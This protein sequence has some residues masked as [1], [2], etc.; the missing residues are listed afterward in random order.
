MR[1]ILSLM[2]CFLGILPGQIKP[3]DGLRENPPRVWTLINSSVHTEPGQ[4]LEDAIIIIRDGII[5]NTGI[6][7][8]IPADATILDM[9]GKTIYPG[10]IDSWVEIPIESENI[11]YHDAHWN[12]K[13]N[14]RSEVYQ[15][16]KFLQLVYMRRL[17]QCTLFTPASF[18]VLQTP[19]TL[20]RI[21][22]RPV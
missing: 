1:I 15:L 9:S 14:A 18:K 11:P 3:T 20:W 4:I 21:S 22:Q 8:N 6:N 16:Y 2:I 10:F 19:K 13:V 7:I 17:L 12:I 5:E